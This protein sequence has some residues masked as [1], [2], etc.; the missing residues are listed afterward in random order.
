MFGIVSSNSNNNA[1]I[2]GIVSHN[3]KNHN[4]HNKTINE[5]Q[6]EKTKTITVRKNSS[7]RFIIK[8]QLTTYYTPITKQLNILSHQQNINVLNIKQALK[9]K[10]KSLKKNKTSSPNPVKL[11]TP[12][13]QPGQHIGNQK[14]SSLSLIKQLDIDT[15]IYALNYKSQHKTFSNIPSQT[16]PHSP[17]NQ[18][19]GHNTSVT[20][21]KQQ[22]TAVKE[23]GKQK[24]NSITT[25]NNSN[26]LN[27][28]K[29]SFN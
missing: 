4:E 8:K 13:K 29:Y 23:S 3:K 24:H 21:P 14:P 9:Q 11:V 12:R 28:F 18:S 17:L 20:P 5:T 2:N 16:Q 1:N 15:N 25:I 27:D 10:I 22:R 7:K 26:Y 19:K 6:N